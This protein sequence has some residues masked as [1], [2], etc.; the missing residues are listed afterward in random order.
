MTA[1]KRRPGRPKNPP[2]LPPSRGSGDSFAR[3]G[4]IG[5]QVGLTREERIRVDH[6]GVDARLSRFEFIR[7]AAVLCASEP[8]LVRRVAKLFTEEPHVANADLLK[9][10][11]GLTEAERT[12]VEHGA[13]DAECTRLRF[14]RFSAV[15]VAQDQTL[16]KRVVG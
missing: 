11:V 13:A 16:L 6:A 5:M 7:R 8:A 9:V 12:Q 1:A 14:M 2:H 4:L 15:L 3:R 10:Q